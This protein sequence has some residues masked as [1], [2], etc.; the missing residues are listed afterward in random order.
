LDSQIEIITKK[1]LEFLIAHAPTREKPPFSGKFSLHRGSDQPDL[2]GM[3]DA[4]YI[5]YTLGLLPKLT[6]RSSRALWAGRILA[7]QDE[8]G[9]FSRKNERG[10]SREHATA[11]ALGGLGLLSVEGYE[12]YIKLI[13]PLRGL[14]P[15]LTD[16]K[17]FSKWISKLNFRL[18]PKSILG[19]NTG[20]H[21]IWR[22]SHVGGGVA[23]ALGMTQPNNSE[24]LP[25]RIDLDLWFNRYFTW[26]D[27]HVN[28]ETGY[29]QRA[30]WNS[31]Y[32]RPSLI[33]MGGA[34][35]FLWVY[36][37]FGRPFPYPEAIIQST[38]PLQ[39]TTGLY[40][41]HPY[42]I[43]LDG[44]FCLI[45][46]YLQLSEQSKSDYKESVYQSTTKNFEAI[47]SEL[48]TNRFEDIYTDSHGLPG[49]LVAL[50][51][52]RNLPEFKYMSD[53]QTWKNPLD[54]VW[55]L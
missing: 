43:D 4:L 14:F 52:C 33:D 13:K 25:E 53:L 20:W 16:E 50:V 9:W 26:L 37:A 38:L 21:Y 29:W 24:W 30:F 49:A 3:I 42:C 40:K 5:I 54:R 12:N 36:D 55:W 51:E 11:Y 1:S 18:T 19:K 47:I 27:E 17:I 6:D 23:A 15:I 35:H 8:E 45:R 2:Y 7:C 41:D 44:N 34:V 39:K 22:G 31:I 46:S 28:A 10:H 32:K 48:S